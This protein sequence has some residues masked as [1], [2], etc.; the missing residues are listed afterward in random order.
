MP[1]RLLI[2]AGSRYR[3][4][5]LLFALHRRRP[6]AMETSFFH[7]TQ[8][9]DT[10]GWFVAVERGQIVALKE[11]LSVSPTYCCVTTANGQ[12]A[13]HV[14]CETGRLDIALA[15]LENGADFLARNH[16]NSTPAHELFR[17]CWTEDDLSRV[18]EFLEK[19][20]VAQP[21]ITFNETTTDQQSL[22]QSTILHS[23]G[24][25][26]PF[27]LS[28][29][30]NLDLP[31]VNGMTPFLLALTLHMKEV[32]IL[33]MEAGADLFL[34]SINGEDSLTLAGELGDE[35]LYQRIFERHEERR[36][37]QTKNIVQELHHTENSF[38]K[39]IETLVVVFKAKMAGNLGVSERAIQFLFADVEDIFKMSQKFFSDLEGLLALPHEQ[40]DVGVCFLK[41]ISYFESYVKY[42]SNQT[43]SSKTL[44]LLLTQSS[45]HS[46][47]TNLY[48]EGN[49]DG[50]KEKIEGYLIK[51]VQR[52]CRYPLL[53]RELIKYSDP[54]SSTHPALL[55]ADQK[56]GEIV[57]RA[58]EQKRQVDHIEEIFNALSSQGVQFS[59]SS[60]FHDEGMIYSV[61]EKGKLDCKYY[62]FSDVWVVV[63][64]EYPSSPIVHIFLFQDISFSPSQTESTA[65]EVVRQESSKKNRFIC[66]SP[67]MR[68]Q[69][70]RKWSHILET[71]AQKLDEKQQDTFQRSIFEEEI[72]ADKRKLGREKVVVDPKLA[73]RVGLGEGEDSSILQ[74]ALNSGENLRTLRQVLEKVSEL[75]EPP[76]KV[77]H[78][79]RKHHFR[80]PRWCEFCNRFIYGLTYQGNKCK[81]CSYS[82]HFNCSKKVGKTCLSPLPQTIWRKRTVNEIFSVS[83]RKNSEEP[84]N[85]TLLLFGNTLEILPEHEVC[86]GKQKQR[87]LYHWGSIVFSL[88]VSVSVE[89]GV[90]TVDAD[91]LTHSF[92]FSSREEALSCC[93]KFS[94]F[95]RRSVRTPPTSRNRKNAQYQ[96]KSMRSSST[97]RKSLITTEG[98]SMSI[99]GSTDS[100]LT[101]SD[102]SSFDIHESFDQPQQP[103][104]LSQQPSQSSQQSQISLSSSQSPQQEQPQQENQ[105]IMT[106]A[107]EYTATQETEMDL[108][109]DQKIIILQRDEDWTFGTSQDDPDQSGW[110]PSDYVE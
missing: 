36:I 21:N 13:A 99:S 42:C 100:D 35:Q 56:L 32:T 72:F 85:T 38:L 23:R 91:G 80:S 60:F 108:K 46:W 15:L 12:T 76:K 48:E 14:A 40:R 81:T 57:T 17:L 9:L 102:S 41:H 1:A 22:L 54:N 27:L 68:D 66:P 8:W 95:M 64:G 101:L 3:L 25:L 62:L 89:G 75:G 50:V 110:F 51:P 33:L 39:Q 7:L 29:G 63:N 94:S 106:V 70:I 28:K 55:E 104:P 31:D 109:F 79:F 90:V 45:I 53:L 65:F 69:L 105:K 78:S 37:T 24:L 6:K 5:T 16:D 103:S 59:C 2:D 10:K 47:I 92:E 83:Y 96:S 84:Q 49:E 98:F 19:V 73:R 107:F 87:F 88:D 58:N 82:A 71:D 97:S 30:V 86:V 43:I 93:E 61:S 11:Y 77:E 18:T 44:N 20:S 4:L 34:R 26:V 67:E 52:I 74:S